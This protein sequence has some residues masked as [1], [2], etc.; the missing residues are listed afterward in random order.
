MEFTD[1]A[2]WWDKVQSILDTAWL[3]EDCEEV[4]DSLPPSW[5]QQNWEQ[6]ETFLQPWLKQERIHESNFVG[7]KNAIGLIELVLRERS[8]P[9]LEKALES[10]TKHRIKAVQE[11][12]KMA[13]WLLSEDWSLYENSEEAGATVA[14][15]LGSLRADNRNML[16]S[17]LIETGIAKVEGLLTEKK[18]VDAQREL[19]G[20]QFKFGR[21]CSTR[22]PSSYIGLSKEETSLSPFSQKWSWKKR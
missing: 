21:L 4:F 10:F 6:L 17:K 9:V 14:R 7:A 2:K 22:R 16:Q 15:E 1:A 18:F 3:T 11:Y 19:L 8:D 20:I 5:V 13:R 12:A